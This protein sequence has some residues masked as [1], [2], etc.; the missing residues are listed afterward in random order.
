MKQPLSH[1][2]IASSHN[3][4]LTGDQIKDPSSTEAYIKL[5]FKILKFTKKVKKT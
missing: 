2:Y 3:T 5:V 4:Y 1:Y